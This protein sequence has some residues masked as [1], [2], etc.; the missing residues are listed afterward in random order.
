M[1]I[2][3]EYDWE[4]DTFTQHGDE[5]AARKAWREAVEAIAEKAKAT[6]PECNGRVD[7][8][9][10]IVLNHDVELLD[11]GKAKV[12]SQSSGKVVYHLVN[13]GCECRDYTDGKAPSGWCKHRI[14]AGLYKRATALI[15]CQL[16]GASN[17]QAALDAAP[18]QMSAQDAALAQPV[19][20]VAAPAHVA[21][22]PEAPV[23][24][25]LKATLHGHEVLVTLRGT[26]E[27]EVLARLTTILR[28]Y[29]IVPS[30]NAKH[31]RAPSGEPSRK[32]QPDWCQIHG[33]AM[34]ETTKDGRSWWSHRT[35]EGW[36]KGR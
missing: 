18:A 11:D 26:S 9:V 12:A 29:P 33:A 17:G 10:Q 21:P 2:V 13:G 27:Q 36:C 34:K 20:P 25:T 15:Q 4:S 23:S 6:L 32:G 24:I 19:A 7:R 16:N 14:A 1:A 35:D 22:L 5:N 31:P 28:Q 30:G 8:A 3:A